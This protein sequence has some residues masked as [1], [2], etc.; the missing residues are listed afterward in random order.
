LCRYAYKTYKPH[1]VCFRCRKQFKRPPVR[2]VLEQLGK[3][4]AYE[5]LLRV[6]HRPVLRAALEQRLGTTIDARKCPNGPHASRKSEPRV[7]ARA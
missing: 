6:F 7:K 3:L 2:D 5:K 1:F 4:D